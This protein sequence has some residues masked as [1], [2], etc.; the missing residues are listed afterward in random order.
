MPGSNESFSPSSISDLVHRQ[1]LSKANCQRS[2]PREHQQISRNSISCHT[3]S[4]KEGTGISL[5]LPL[6]LLSSIPPSP[7]IALRPSFFLSFPVS[8]LSS[9][10]SPLSRLSSCQQNRLNSPVSDEHL[11]LLHMSV[12]SPRYHRRI[13]PQT[14]SLYQVPRMASVTESY[15]SSTHC[16][17]LHHCKSISPPAGKRI[18]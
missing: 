15:W 16:S 13:H 8:L 18:C 9:L 4:G 3:T 10:L 12:C 5:F 2:E 14:R 6:S 7:L 17:I 11:R 1:G